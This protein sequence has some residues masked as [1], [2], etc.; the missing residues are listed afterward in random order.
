MS[1]LVPFALVLFAAM[2][3][4]AAADPWSGWAPGVP[5]FAFAAGV[6]E[7]GDPEVILRYDWLDLG[8][9]APLVGLSIAAN[10]SGW[11]GAGLGLRHRFR[12]SRVFIE[13]SVMPGLYRQGAGRDLGG[14]F[15]IR[16]SL[17]LGY[18][19]ASATRISLGLDHRSNANLNRPNPGLNMVWLMVSMPLR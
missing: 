2:A 19:T 6:S 14:A 12:Q 5:R 11:I 10:G 17:A 13:A 9:I 7:V 3:P 1:R 4:A 8:G 18:E 16:S 15:Q